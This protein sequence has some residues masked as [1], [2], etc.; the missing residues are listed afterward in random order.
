MSV[1]MLIFTKLLK[2]TLMPFYKK[3][4]GSLRKNLGVAFVLKDLGEN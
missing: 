2:E 3:V 4:L 1:V